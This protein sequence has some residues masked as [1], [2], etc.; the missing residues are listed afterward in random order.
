MATVTVKVMQPK[1]IP[2]FCAVGRLS[3]P[4]IARTLLKSW[5]SLRKDSAPKIFSKSETS[6][7]LMWNVDVWSK[8]DSR[9]DASLL[10][11]ILDV[12]QVGGG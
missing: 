4:K 2:Y 3:I 10:S 1:M 11:G 7:L 9:F 6:D 5:I 12:C 8:V